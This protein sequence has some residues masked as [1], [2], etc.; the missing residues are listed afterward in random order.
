MAKPALKKCTAA[1]GKHRWQFV[2]NVVRV[3]GNSQQASFMS[4]G[5]YRCEV[6]GAKKHGEYRQQFG[7]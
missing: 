6:C 2:R 3:S 1:S 4:L 7:V 5:I